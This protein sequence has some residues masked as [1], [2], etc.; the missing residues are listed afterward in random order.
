MRIINKAIFLLIL[1]IA[2]N[3]I[4]SQ[5]FLGDIYDSFTRK[6]DPDEL[7]TIDQIIVAHK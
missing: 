4:S 1:L 3:F 7:K 5:S 2:I 6:R